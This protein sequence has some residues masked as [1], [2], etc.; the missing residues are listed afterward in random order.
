M[1]TLSSSNGS[2]VRV[3]P[4]NVYV[5]EGSTAP[6]SQPQVTGVSLGV[7]AVSASA[8]G[9]AGTTQEV[10]VLGKLSGPQSQTIQQGS[11]LNIMFVLSWPVPTAVTLVVSSDNSAVASTQASVTIPANGSMAVVPVT[12]V[13]TGTTVIH[14][15]ALPDIAESMVSITVQ[16]PGSITISSG[17]SVALGQSATL[18]VT[19]GTPAPAGGLVVTLASSQSATVSISPSS[20]FIPAGATTPNA[21][22]VLTGHNVGVATIT[23]SAPG[24]LT[25]SQQVPVT[26]T[27][28]MSP[29]TLVIPT[30]GIRLLG[31]ALSAAAPSIGVPI[32]PDRGATGFVEGL[33]VQLSSSNSGVA[34]LQ[35]TVQ[36]YPDGSSI[37]TVMVLVTGVAPGTAV[38]HASALPSIPDVTATVIVQ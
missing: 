2:K 29:A 22:P 19:L 27:I 37:T 8:Y 28:T 7:A 11:T 26:A 6:F 23:A 1:V 21:Q 4:A 25:A 24:Y 35:P 33:T 30:G 5:P 3:S 34:T 10:Q 18:P 15:G 14:V 31:L 20:V 38:I 32:T 13:S 17:V 12:A 16:A 36:F 9:F